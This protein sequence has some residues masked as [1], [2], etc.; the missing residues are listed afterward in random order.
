MNNK[1]IQYAFKCKICKDFIIGHYGNME[2][3]SCEKVYID[4]GSMYIRINGDKEYIKNK[5]IDLIIEKNDSIENINEKFIWNS[6][7]LNKK[8]ESV[9]DVWYDKIPKQ[10]DEFNKNLKG[11]GVTLRNY[12]TEF[13]WTKYLK[14]L[15][16]RPISTPNF[17]KDLESNHIHNIINTQ[18]LSLPIKKAFILELNKRGINTEKL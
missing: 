4:V 16:N 14:W 2:G 9:L 15:D 10:V 11:S 18:I 6:Y 12:L 1:Y 17:M 13:Q 5:W 3:C 7:K 8:G